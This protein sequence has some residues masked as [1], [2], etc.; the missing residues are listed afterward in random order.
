VARLLSI[1]E[2]PALYF[3]AHA[4]V[5]PNACAYVFSH[6]L[7]SHFKASLLCENVLRGD[8]Y[9]QARCAAGLTRKY[10]DSYTPHVPARASLAC[11]Y[12][13]KP[14]GIG[15][16]TG[17]EGTVRAYLDVLGTAMYISDVHKTTSL[18]SRKPQEPQ[19]GEAIDL[20]WSGGYY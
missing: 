14:A 7:C 9:L 16:Q 13:R 10:V 17:A 2:D 6:L 1:A 3:A 18:A 4:A 5:L 19:C 15:S 8:R 12:R 11:K 20:R